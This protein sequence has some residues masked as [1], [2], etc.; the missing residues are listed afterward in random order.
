[1]SVAAMATE[2]KGR[3][4]YL[5]FYRD[6]VENK[7]ASVEAGH[8]VMVDVDFVEITAPYSKDTIVYRVEEWLPRLKEMVS[9]GKIPHEWKDLY[10]R[11]YEA[12]KNGQEL[13][14]NGIPIKGW[15]VISPA[16]QEN[17]IHA[18][19]RTVEDLAQVNEDGLRRIGMGGVELRNKAKAWL[20]QLSDKGPLTQQMAAV[21]QE[22]DVLRGSIASL[23]NQIE[24]MQKAIQAQAMGA[25]TPAATSA[26]IN[27]DDILDAPPAPRARRAKA[28]E[29]EI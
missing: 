16:T 23:Q 7:A 14:T 1:M 11:Q 15:G 24:Q 12:W 8:A 22:N 21:Q 4:G 6:A 29:G 5:R 18:R 13:P 20:A 19:I 3:P 27:A 10:L 2:R 9:R 26:S 28:A 17:L 25:V